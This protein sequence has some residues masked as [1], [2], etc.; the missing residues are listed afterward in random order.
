MKKLKLNSTLNHKQ[1]DYKTRE[2]IVEKVITLYG[3]SFSELKNHTL[4]DDPYIAQNRDL[5]YIDSSDTAHCLL[6]VDNDSGDGILVESEGMSYARKSQFIP[7]ASAL[8]ENS[9]LTVS[10]R[11]L[12]N[13]L[14]KMV[15]HIAELAHCGENSFVFEELLEK[16]DLDLKSLLRDSVV[17]MLQEREDIKM[18]ESHS[19][20]VDFQPDI[21]VEAKPTQELTLYCPLH[22]V[23][24]YDESEY[25]FDEEV[26]DEQEKIPSKYAVDCADEINNFIQDYS[27]P[28]EEHR[29]LMVYFDDD[30][31]VSEKV[32]SAIPS[33]KEINGELMGVF[34]CQITEALTDNELR[35]LREYLSGQAS[36]GWGESVEQR[37]IKTA[38]YGEIYVSFW[39]DGSDW[40]LQTAEEMGLEQIEDLSEEPEMNMTM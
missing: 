4:D 25:E 19:I 14:K 21:T 37:P 36:D 31:A 1:S 39:N 10:E 32:F 35:D 34:K 29:G 28:E 16:S 3:K 26:L 38:D 5:M 24:E 6:M 27:E 40:S 8:V 11:K 33:V 18:A 22:I 15:D 9:E 7:N 20:D 17:T 23:K 30:P 13:S 12:H 2:V